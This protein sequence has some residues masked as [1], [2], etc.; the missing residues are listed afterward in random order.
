MFELILQFNKPVCDFREKRLLFGTVP[1]NLTST[2]IVHIENRGRCHAY[3]KV[4]VT[5]FTDHFFINSFIVEHQH[6]N[7]DKGA[8]PSTW[9]EYIL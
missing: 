2:R 4:H 1:L 7:S 8:L 3:F 5:F 6:N 9:N